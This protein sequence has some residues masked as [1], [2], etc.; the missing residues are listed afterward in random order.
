MF[1][2]KYIKL[3]YWNYPNFGDALSP[4][5]VESLSKKEIIYKT[6]YLGKKDALRKLKGYIISKEFKEIKH[7]N[8]PWEKTLLAVGSIISWGT[9]NSEIWGSGFMNEYETFKGGKIH[10]VRGK[11]T[12][13]KLTQSGFNCP[14]V[15]GDPA[16]LLP[17]IVPPAEKKE[18][19]GIIPHW[20]ETKYFQSNFAN[21]FK[22]IDLNTNNIHEIIAQITSC[23]KILS[24][25]LH[26]IIV[27]HAY[28]IP[29][30][31]IMKGYIDTDGFKF[32]DYFS[33]VNIPIYDGFTNIEE[34]LSKQQNIT[35]LFENNKIQSLPHKSITEIQKSLIFAAPFKV[36]KDITNK[37]L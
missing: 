36:C 1:K 11:Y 34:I 8:F 28:G 37:I 29:A 3:I 7:I 26:G 25:S 33:S 4:F 35:N 2:G 30:L 22:V 20:K 5:I 32:K 27:A 21:K 15:Y 12:K 14:D 23:Q 9:K 17:L 18:D 19:I 13:E 16:L 31:W 6:H 24:T 10:A